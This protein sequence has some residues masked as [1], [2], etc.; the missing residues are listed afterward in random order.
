MSE[1][2]RLACPA[3]RKH[4]ELWAGYA[5]VVLGVVVVAVEPSHW[6]GITLGVLL[7]LAGIALAVH[8][9]MIKSPVLEVSEGEFRYV[10]GRYVVRIPF[11]DIGS[12]YVLPGRIRSLGLCDTTGRPKRFPS[13]QSRRTSRTHLP[14]TGLTSPAR[15]DSFMA[16]VGIPPRNQ[17][18]TS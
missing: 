6:A 16:M 10:R 2:V 12:Y 5:L 15:V 14:L 3:G 4:M 1:T 7:S 8:G 17:S 13:L 9:H 11:Q 18:L